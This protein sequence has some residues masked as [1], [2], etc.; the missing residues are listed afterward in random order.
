MFRNHDPSSLGKELQ[1]RRERGYGIYDH[2]VTQSRQLEDL[3]GTTRTQANMGRKK[4]RTTATRSCEDMRAHMNPSKRL[5]SPGHSA[6]A[7]NSTDLARH[8][9]DVLDPREDDG[10]T[11]RPPTRTKPSHCARLQ[12]TDK[13]NTTDESEELIEDV[14]VVSS[15]Q[16]SKGK[17]V[18]L[19]DKRR[20]KNK[21]LSGGI[22]ENG[23]SSG[24]QGSAIRHQTISKTT[25]DEHVMDGVE[26]GNGE[27]YLCLEVLQDTT[28]HR[29]SD[30]SILI[31]SGCVRN[32][33]VLL[34]GHV[35]SE[36]QIESENGAIS[37]AP[38]VRQGSDTGGRREA[39]A[40]TESIV[41]DSMVYDCTFCG[42]LPDVRYECR[43]CSINLCADCL[44]MHPSQHPVQEYAC[45]NGG[46][47]HSA[48]ATHEDR[49]DPGHCSAP[50][51][52]AISDLHGGRPDDA[53]NTAGMD[54]Q[55]SDEWLDDDGDHDGSDEAVGST[56]SAVVQA[57]K[58]RRGPSLRSQ[59][60][61]SQSERKHLSRHRPATRSGPGTTP[62]LFP[63]KKR[64]VIQVYVTMRNMLKTMETF[65]GIDPAMIGQ[66]MPAQQSALRGR[67]G[68]SQTRNPPD[69]DEDL[70]EAEST[71]GPKITEDGSAVNS[72]DGVDEADNDATNVDLNEHDLLDYNLSEEDDPDYGNFGRSHHDETRL[73]TFKRNRVSSSRR[74]LDSEKE[75]LHRLKVKGWTD[76]RI[77][78][79]LGRSTSAIIQQ[80]RKQNR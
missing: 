40:E 52:D 19:Q 70:S 21:D 36:A 11:P 24:F 31:C 35:F 13:E 38:T 60:L 18:Q 73:F 74:W 50:D 69:G 7:A 12:T 58:P 41:G 29:C 78:A 63:F 45:S 37:T 25:E 56:S 27:C 39:S 49:H 77:A 57:L 33:S 16:K 47:A 10:E 5:K 44:V 80:W 48:R 68:R 15:Q 61:R 32:A 14:I 26:N 54:G 22:F 64:E 65:L 62:G 9:G 28:R 43:I 23:E 1:A 6:S 4:R 30:C 17:E 20:E 72:E 71:P 42:E 66:G 79:N 67:K 59:S 2:P 75:K 8:L 53:L 46:T 76:E 55:H 3:S 34:P 51:V